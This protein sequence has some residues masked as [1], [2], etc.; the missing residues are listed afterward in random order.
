MTHRKDKRFFDMIKNQVSSGNS[1]VAMDFHEFSFG[2]DK[3]A[4]KNACKEEKAGENCFHERIDNIEKIKKNSSVILHTTTY[5]N[6]NHIDNGKI[7]E[8]RYTHHKVT[9]NF[10]VC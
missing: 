5:H 10:A 2:A 8:G 6:G 9:E 3:R 4:N 1:V 7:E